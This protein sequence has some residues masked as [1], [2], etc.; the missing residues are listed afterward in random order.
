MHLYIIL[1]TLETAYCLMGL[2]RLTSG[3]KQ[4]DIFSNEKGVFFHKISS[5]ETSEI[6]TRTTI[7]SMRI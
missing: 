6:P 5:I 1:Y 7:F 4:M 3:M 2:P